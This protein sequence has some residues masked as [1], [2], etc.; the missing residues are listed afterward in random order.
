[1]DVV[2][3]VVADLVREHAR[4]LVHAHALDERV[5]QDDA[6]AEDAGEVRVRVAGAARRVHHV[7]PAVARTPRLRASASSRSRSAPSGSGSNRLK[8]GAMKVG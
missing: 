4:R 7:E 2:R 6:R 5:E 8:S 3:P 1:M